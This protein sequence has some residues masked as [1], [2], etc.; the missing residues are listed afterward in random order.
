MTAN[1][2]IYNVVIA[3]VR[4]QTVCLLTVD[5]RRLLNRSGYLIWSTILFMRNKQNAIQCI[6]LFIIHLNRK[7]TLVW[8]FNQMNFFEMYGYCVMTT[9]LYKG[10]THPGYY[11]DLWRREG[12]TYSCTLAE[13]LNMKPVSD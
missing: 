8:I 5:I 13:H 1:R 9:L 3:L 11:L 12:Y 10:L 4:L 6:M 7:I 2:L